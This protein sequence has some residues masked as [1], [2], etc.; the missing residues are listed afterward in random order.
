MTFFFFKHRVIGSLLSYFTP[1]LSFPCVGVRTVLQFLKPPCYQC[2]FLWPWWTWLASLLMVPEGGSGEPFLTILG[3][4]HLL[5]IK[6]KTKEG[7]RHDSMMYS[8]F[9]I[10]LI[11]LW[12]GQ[13]EL[14]DTNT[15]LAA[16][17]VGAQ[18]AC[19]VGY[20]LRLSLCLALEDIS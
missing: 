16:R 6:H 2:S 11:L 18:H 19:L 8:V 14:M 9:N 10:L 20:S 13:H 3:V 12:W 1:Q 4:L 17:E 7:K 5:L 15:R